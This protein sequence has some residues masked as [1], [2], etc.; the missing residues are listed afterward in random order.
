MPSAQESDA[1]QH[2]TPQGCHKLVLRT[3]SMNGVVAEPERRASRHGARCVLRRART[4][5]LMYTRQELTI[6]PYGPIQRPS[7]APIDWTGAFQLSCTI[8]S[9]HEPPTTSTR[10]GHPSP[11]GVRTSRHCRTHPIMGSGSVCWS[12]HRGRIAHARVCSRAR[13]WVC[14]AGAAECAYPRRKRLARS[15]AAEL[16]DLAASARAPAMPLPSTVHGS[17]LN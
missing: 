3:P 5:S 8:Y 14:R 16:P 15:R 9:Y 12:V 7:R 11:D 2:A 13:V 4:L 17:F 6:P 1:A 10:V